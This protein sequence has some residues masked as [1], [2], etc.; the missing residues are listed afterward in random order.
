MAV[1][2]IGDVQGCYKQF[3]QLLDKIEFDPSND[4]LYLTGDLVNRG[5]NS[6]EVLRYIIN[7]QASIKTV[8]GNHDLHLLACSEGLSAIRNGHTF[9]DVLNAPDRS[10][11]IYWLRRQPLAIYNT[12]LNV[13]LV[14]ASVYP[15]W[16]V[17]DTL[18]YAGEVEHT[19]QSES[20]SKFLK[21]L[22]GN[23][24][25]HWS[26]DLKGNKRLRFIVNVLTRLRYLTRDGKLNFCCSEKPGLQPSHL[27]PWFKHPSRIKI[28]PKIVFGHWSTLKI[29]QE[30]EVLSLDT[31]C[32]WGRR[33]SAARLDSSDINITKVKCR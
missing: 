12:Q 30:D 19:L 1:Y 26:D 23:T 25:Q 29:Y 11:L 7:N 15:T 33:L 5:P 8:L 21:K 22:Y 20:Y 6:L 9:D 32:C 27:V 10:D 18:N 16:S 3:R 14:H 17:Q 13:L 31:G 4:Q 2:A 28:L 24:P